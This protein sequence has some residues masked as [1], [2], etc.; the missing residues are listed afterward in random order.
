MKKNYFL[1][2]LI[3]MTASVSTAQTYTLYQ[4]DG[5]VRGAA[6]P[7]GDTIII[8]HNQGSPEYHFRFE[9]GATG[10]T[11]DIT[12]KVR[13]LRINPNACYTYQLCS[14]ITPDNHFQNN[15][16]DINSADY[17]SPTLTQLDP[18]TESIIFY[19]KGVPCAGSTQLRYIVYVND[20][21][22]DSVDY[23]INNGTLA[24]PTV[25]KEEATISVY[26]NPAS[27]L[28]TVATKGLDDDFD[29]K[30]TDVLGKV[31]YNESVA[32]TSK[33]VDVSDFKNGVYLVTVTE[34]GT[35]IQTRRIVVK[36]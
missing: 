22:V 17:M 32:G 14:E 6:I 8:N 7:S 9:L 24:T 13:V 15:C 29:I 20:V 12:T 4:H 30:M 34:K 23:I 18:A 36:H 19:P 16:W 26:P 25:S 10:T 33:K 35:A 31:V 5:L 11:G 28:I 1:L 2:L 27:S 3:L 21:V